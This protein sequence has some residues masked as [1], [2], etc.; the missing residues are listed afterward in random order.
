[1]QE[2]SSTPAKEGERD[3]FEA[4]LT[5]EKEAYTECTWKSLPAQIQKEYLGQFK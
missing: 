4:E 1:M 2:G 5:I 3:L